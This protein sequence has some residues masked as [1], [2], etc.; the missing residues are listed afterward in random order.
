MAKFKEGDIVQITVPGYK[1]PIGSIG[2]I[3]DYIAKDR[4]S[5]DFGKTIGIIALSEWNLKSLVE[6][7]Y[8]STID[9][10]IEAVKPNPIVPSTG[11]G[12][13]LTDPNV[14]YE[15]LSEEP[16][17]YEF[18]DIGK[19]LNRLKHYEFETPLKQPTLQEYVELLSQW[20]WQYCIDQIRSHRVELGMSPLWSP[21]E[22]PKETVA[23]IQ[24]EIRDILKI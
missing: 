7:V 14:D 15:A 9:N 19:A 10:V 18:I 22:A 23:K 8:T 20:V 11:Y 2:V 24:K 16:V 5:V 6:A 3:V 4:I 12:D 1:A 21:A 13:Y 17:Y